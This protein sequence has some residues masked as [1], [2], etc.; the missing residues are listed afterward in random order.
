MYTFAKMPPP[1]KDK[2]KTHVS[3]KGKKREDVDIR[4]E[5][6]DAFHRPAALMERT[7]KAAGIE[8]PPSIVVV[9]DDPIFGGII[10]RK[11]RKHGMSVVHIAGVEELNSVN[12]S[13]FDVAVVDYFLEGMNGLQMTKLIEEKCKGVLPVV[14]ISGTM[15]EER[16]PDGV[17]SFVPKQDGIEA[18]L[19]QA[20][21]ARDAHH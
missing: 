10:R 4:G 15:R 20:V 2:G 11:A 18:I 13:H 5:K 1:E 19:D 16:V 12:L 8:F 21:E 7:R 6:L 14:L 3:I 9:D 17:F